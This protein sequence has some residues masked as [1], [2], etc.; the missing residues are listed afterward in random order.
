MIYIERTTEV[1]TIRIPRNLFAPTKG[2]YALSVEN[3][4]DKTRIAV[5]PEAVTPGTL[6]YT[7]EVVFADDMP[8]GEYRYELTKGGC[9]LSSGLLVVGD[10]IS[11]REEYN[12]SVHYQQYE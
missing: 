7:V 9:L 11:P 12:T 6:Y 8:V 1:Q 3:T 2:G 10:Y 4:V 5:K